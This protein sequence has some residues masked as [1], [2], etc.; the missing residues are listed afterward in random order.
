MRGKIKTFYSYNIFHSNFYFAPDMGIYSPQFWCGIWWGDKNEIILVFI[1]SLH[2]KQICHFLFM[3]LDKE[4]Y[5]MQI[6]C[7]NLTRS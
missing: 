2:L 7:E 1:S 5:E 4:N 3:T 6:Y